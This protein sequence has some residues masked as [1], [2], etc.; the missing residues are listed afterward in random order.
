MEGML[1]GM[2]GG[3]L[4]GMVEGLSKG[5]K[6]LAINFGKFADCKRTPYRQAKHFGARAAEQS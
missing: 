4:E 6:G 2:I 1:A 5:I 3:V